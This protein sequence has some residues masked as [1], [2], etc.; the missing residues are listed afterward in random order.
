MKNLYLN[1]RKIIISYIKIK[2]KINSFF[3]NNNL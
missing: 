3:K 2:N 1:N